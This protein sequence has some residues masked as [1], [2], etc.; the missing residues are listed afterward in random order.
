[1]A[2]SARNRGSAGAARSAV[3]DLGSMT[4]DTPVVSVLV[5]TRNRRENVLPTIR[6]VQAGGYARF[7]LLILDQSDDDNT[8]KVST[9]L[10]AED[11]RLRYFR[12]PRPGKPLALNEGLKH[13]RGRYV[14]LT[15]DDCEAMPGWVDA[16]VAAF[17]GDARVGCIYGSVD[18]ATHDAAEGYVPARAVTRAHTVFGLDSFLTRAWGN[19]GMGA[20]MAVRTDVI[21]RLGG[22]DPCIGPGTKFG[23]GDDTDLAVRTL[24]AGHGLHF[25][26][27]A[28]VVHYGFRLW[29]SSRKDFT[30]IGFGLGAV[31]A[32]HLRCGAFFPGGLRVAAHEAAQSAKRLSRWQRPGSVSFLSGW[33]RGLLAGLRQPVDRRTNRFVPDEG[34]SDYHG[35]VA[36]VVLRSHQRSST[37]QET[38]AT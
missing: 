10:C 22:W 12:L 13:V 1:M 16:I 23:S 15:D 21:S 32:K 6:S 3:A 5:C 33:L 18:A 14:L 20:N 17:E 19:F 28:K 38:K 27:S 9:A 2:S 37:N 30:R 24:R 8:E 34:G 35:R 7:E 26:P 25:C 36:E 29:K 4:A 31:F 11:T